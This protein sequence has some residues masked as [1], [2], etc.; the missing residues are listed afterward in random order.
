MFEQI[1]T[2]ACVTWN[3]VVD[4]GNP[5]PNTWQMQF[6]TSSGFVHFV[7]QTMSLGGN[8]HLVFYSPGGASNDPGNRDIS[9]TLP[10]GFSVTL[11]DLNPLGLAAATRP[12]SGTTCNLLTSNIPPSTPF[13]AVLLGLTQFDP[14]IDLTAIGMPGCFRYTDGA[15]SLLFVGPGAANTTGIA[16]PNGFAGLHVFVQSAIFNPGAGLTALGAIASNG[17]NLGIDNL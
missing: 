2:V 4:F 7:W 6:D 11:A 14:G 15:A 10:G 8:G 12:V 13:G 17:V 1:G 9:A 5:V 16:I 3:A